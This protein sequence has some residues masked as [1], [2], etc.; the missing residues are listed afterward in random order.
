[1][2]QQRRLIGFPTDP[3]IQRQ[4]GDDK[5]LRQRRGNR[6]LC[7][8]LSL[9]LRMGWRCL[10]IEK[11][12]EELTLLDDGGRHRFPILLVPEWRGD[13]FLATSDCGNQYD[14]QQRAR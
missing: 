11:P 7:E 9:E 5:S 10:W 6:R 3:R 4:F 13:G 2:G 8:H 12:D 1:M 14:E